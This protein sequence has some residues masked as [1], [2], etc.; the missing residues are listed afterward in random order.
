MNTAK[1][2]RRAMTRTLRGNLRNTAAVTL[3][4]TTGRVIGDIDD[5]TTWTGTP[6]AH[7]DPVKGLV[8]F[9]SPE[10]VVNRGF[11]E[12]RAGDAIVDFDPKVSFAGMQELTF[13]IDGRRYG[14]KAVGKEVTAYYDTIVSGQ[15]MFRTV[16]LTLLGGKSVEIAEGTGIVR[17][18]G[19]STVEDLY[20]YDFTARIFTPSGAQAGRID[21]GGA[22]GS[23]L[24]TIRVNGTLAL[25][26]ALD[27]TLL[28]RSLAAM[29]ATGITGTP[30]AEFI[31]GAG[32]YA[33]LAENGTL[34]AAAFIEQPARPAL[35]T[36][37]EFLNG[38]TWLFSIGMAGIYAP[39][40]SDTLP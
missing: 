9:I 38:S 16:V 6:V 32:Y 10:T 13:E 2:I 35:A 30:R 33:A 14:Q 19:G 1:L 11:I 22:E 28:C 40:I 5:E 21:I 17:W 4:Y 7:A 8:H 29:E 26:V 20:A 36:D 24:S 23:W 37:F 39:Q 15:R 12:L 25:A 27:G 34:T 31:G 18:V 3:H